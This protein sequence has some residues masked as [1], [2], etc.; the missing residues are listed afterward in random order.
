M[1]ERNRI[2][3]LRSSSGPCGTSASKNSESPGCQRVGLVAVPVADL[4]FE[5]VDELDALMLEQRETRRNAPVSA[6]MY[7]STAMLLRI[8]W[9]SSWYWW[10]ARVPRRSIFS[11]CP[12][13][14]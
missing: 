8:V 4:A 5:H 12:A 9:P 7:G 3:S 2:G 11:P 10:P 13:L 14:T 6:I 1:T